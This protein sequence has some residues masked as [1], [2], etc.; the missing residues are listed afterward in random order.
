MQ[1]DEQRLFVEYTMA[2]H[3]KQMKLMYKA[4]EWQQVSVT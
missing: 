3:G 4:D 2:E 1:P